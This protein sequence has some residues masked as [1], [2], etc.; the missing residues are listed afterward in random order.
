MV[1]T[2][3]SK[4]WYFISCRS[5]AA[6]SLNLRAFELK[7]VESITGFAGDS[8]APKFFVNYSRWHSKLRRN[9]AVAVLRSNLFL[10]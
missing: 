4:N 3:Y 10:S 1:L 8:A 7:R 2:S 6:D 9:T 5:P